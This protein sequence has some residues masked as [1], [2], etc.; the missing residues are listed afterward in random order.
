MEKVEVTDIPFTNAVDISYREVD[1]D[2]LLSY[3]TAILLSDSFL[4][5]KDDRGHD[6]YFHIINR[7]SGKLESEIGRKGNGPEELLYASWNPL[8]NCLKNELQ[9]FDTNGKK[10]CRYKLDEKNVDCTNIIDIAQENGLF[11]SELLDF[12]NHYL[13]AGMNGLLD[14]YRFVVFDKLFKPINHFEKYPLWD[15]DAEINEKINKE[16]FNSYF[17]KVSPDRKHLLFASYRVGFMEIFNLEELPEKINK[18]KSILLTKPMKN[19][20]ENIFGFEDIYVTDHYIYALH[21]GKTAEENPYFTQAIKVF[22]WQGNPIVMYNIGVNMLCLAVDENMKVIY[23]TAYTDEE[24]FFLIQI[25]LDD[26]FF[27]IL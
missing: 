6:F 25:A 16:V 7:V 13:A 4:I 17:L 5:I 18:I 9:V 19:E 10:L 12:D 24:G 26:S 14:E 20:K 1:T 11:L 2:L 15:D 3:P 22:D 27:P 23:A 21:N 8:F